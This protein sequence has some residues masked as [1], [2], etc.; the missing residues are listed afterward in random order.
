MDYQLLIKPEKIRKGL[1][2]REIE[3]L[4]DLEINNISILRRKDGVTGSREYLYGLVNWLVENFD[5]YVSNEMPKIVTPGVKLFK[6]IEK[7]E[8]EYCHN[9]AVEGMPVYLSPFKQFTRWQ[10]SHTFGYHQMKFPIVF[11]RR[12]NQM[13]ISWDLEGPFYET[14]EGCEYVS[15]QRFKQGTIKS[16][17]EVIDTFEL[18]KNLIRGYDQFSD[19]IK[20][21][22][23][24]SDKR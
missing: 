11:Q 8:E 14:P 17:N 12:G 1:N 5:A 6:G 18:H 23:D 20:H 13:E 19:I 24:V 16:V 22:R 21:F 9:I 2:L 7:R 4:V 10:Y 3:G 15:L